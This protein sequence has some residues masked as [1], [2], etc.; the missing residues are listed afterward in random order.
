MVAASPLG[1]PICGHH[2]RDGNGATAHG[3][4][5]SVSFFA[6]CTT[7][8]RTTPRLFAYQPTDLLSH[9]Q[10][11]WVT[12]LYN[13]L[14]FLLSEPLNCELCISKKKKEIIGGP[15]VGRVAT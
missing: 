4:T 3:D 2:P 8:H 12:N 14:A 7:L 13:G 10:G 15:Q 1:T 9:D 11:G 6:P 5:T